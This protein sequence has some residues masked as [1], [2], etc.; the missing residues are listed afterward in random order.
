VLDVFCVSINVASWKPVLPPASAAQIV[1]DGNTLKN[2]ESMA[3]KET[4][5][6][7]SSKKAETKI[8]SNEMVI[9]PMTAPAI[10]ADFRVAWLR[11]SQILNTFAPISVGISETITPMDVRNMNAIHERAK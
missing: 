5:L 11:C 10:R 1:T 6:L 9:A 8:N 4:M 2:R 3:S 7:L